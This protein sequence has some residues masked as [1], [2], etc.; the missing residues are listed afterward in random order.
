MRGHKGSG[1]RQIDNGHGRTKITLFTA[2]KTH[3]IKK[4]QR[5]KQK[6]VFVLS[7][8]RSGTFLHP[9]ISRHDGTEK[10][11]P[12]PTNLHANSTSPLHDSA[13]S[14]YQHHT[15]VHHI[16]DLTYLQKEYSQHLDT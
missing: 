8:L 13:T 14:A 9:V 11:Q 7:N 3:S 16:F 4:S 1:F 5:A 6:T 2:T 15:H 12:N 10:N